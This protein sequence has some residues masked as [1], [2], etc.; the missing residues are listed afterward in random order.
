MKGMNLEVMREVAR[1]MSAQ[2][3]KLEQ[4]QTRVN[5]ML[6]ELDWLGI[7]A[8][9]FRDS[10]SA[11][12]QPK[13]REVMLALQALALVLARNVDEQDRTSNSDTS[14]NPEPSTP[15]PA[16]E[17]PATPPA[18]SPQTT[19]VPAPA[20]PD[21]GI[22][23]SDPA[24]PYDDPESPSRSA[25]P[26]HSA[27]S[28]P[29]VS[30]QGEHHAATGTGVAHGS[31]A[32]GADPERPDFVPEDGRANDLDTY[33]GANTA[34]KGLESGSDVSINKALDV[35]GGDG[36][37]DVVSAEGE[38]TWW[39][40][41]ASGSADLGAGF[42]ASGTAAV[43]AGSVA[44]TASAGIGN[45]KVSASAEGTATAFKAEASGK[46]GNDVI[47]ATGVASAE[48]G[49]K[50]KAEASIGVDGA[51][52]GVGGSA[53]AGVQASA[54]VQGDVL[55]VKPSA[56][57]HV[58]AGIGAHANADVEVSASHVKASV[59]AGVA[60]GVGAGLSFDVDIDVNEI[61]D[62]LGKVFHF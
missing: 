41:E 11:D 36:T 44:G 32:D 52:A 37:Y 27:P 59:D 6:R 47:A 33:G 51:K 16:D 15:S 1:G 38:A 55:G 49:A 45:G 54:T 12:L 62:N 35:L 48:V 22:F 28:I 60:L 58:Y 10:W 4:S 31:N 9:S 13:A 57:G 21:P 2:S 50:G 19:D 8:S 34:S 18:E 26:T 46:I 25:D 43:V 14:T 61:S 3:K 24:D 53:F 30:A 42:A 7:D 5:R 29:K 56:T 40:Q 17:P 39:E 20:E 23:G